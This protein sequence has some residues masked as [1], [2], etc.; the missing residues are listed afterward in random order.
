MEYLTIGCRCAIAIVFI[1]S[2]VTKLS[3]AEAFRAFKRSVRRMKVVPKPLISL[4]AYAVVASEIVISVL[5]VIP[6]TVT[7]V[8]G[9]TIAAGLLCAFTYGIVS[10][11]R[12][13]D[14]TPCRCFGK[15]TTPLGLRHVIRNIFL[16][17]LCVLGFVSALN[18]GTVDFAMAGIAFVA[19]AVVGGIITV[20][21][22][23]T[24]LVWPSPKAPST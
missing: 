17:G 24:E 14:Q 21:D 9:F 6:I 5:M 10:S 15:S 4:A 3:G 19:G 22:D 23:V 16:I 11:M 2:A 12:R 18:A 8:V 13:G 20:L 7:A 1:T